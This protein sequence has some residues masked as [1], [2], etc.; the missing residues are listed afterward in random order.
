MSKKNRSILIGVAI[1]LVLVIAALAVYN[2]TRPQAQ[3]GS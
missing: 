3:T 1:L 2:G